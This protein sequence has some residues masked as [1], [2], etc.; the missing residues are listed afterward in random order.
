MPS[1][2]SVI[3]KQ[4]LKHQ[5]SV[6]EEAKNKLRH[7]KRHLRIR[8]TGLEESRLRMVRAPGGKVGVMEARKVY[9]GAA[10]QEKSKGRT[11][12]PELGI[13]RNDGVAS[14]EGSNA[15]P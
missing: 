10:G 11:T 14:R 3:L 4:P 13:G 1:K 15:V 12:G 2:T 7:L 8:D 5:R 6:K 9:G